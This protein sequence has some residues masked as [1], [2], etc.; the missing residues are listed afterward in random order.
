MRKTN[1]TLVGNAYDALLEIDNKT[2]F[3][4]PEVRNFFKNTYQMPFHLK[5]KQVFVETLI[6]FD[7][8]WRQQ[9]NRTYVLY[10]GTLIG[11]YRH[12]ETVPW[13]DDLDILVDYKYKASLHRDFNGTQ[14]ALRKNQQIMKL[15]FT[16]NGTT[17]NQ[18]GHWPFIDLFF[19]NATN[20]GANPNLKVMG[21]KNV[22]P[23]K[24][25]FPAIKIRFEGR[26]VLAP[27]CIEEVIRLTSGSSVMNNCC[28]HT[29]NHKQDKLYKS[30]CI[31]CA[32]LEFLFPFLSW[33]RVNAT[34][35]LPLMSKPF[36]LDEMAEAHRKKKRVWEEGPLV[37]M[38][39]C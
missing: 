14:F 11:A 35:S 31:S 21:Y 16:H 26:E 1:K 6:E 30:R 37:F 29:Y 7:R 36:E 23:T 5:Y 38:P 33:R 32:K 8:I 27:R 12:G 15:F 28:T 24:V 39:K 3:L 25:L 22:Y 9:L 13:D 17:T 34:H 20:P 10:G 18:Y 4:D 2:Q 19:Y